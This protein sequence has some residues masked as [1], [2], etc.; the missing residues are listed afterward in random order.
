MT[1]QPDL[2]AGFDDRGM[3]AFSFFFPTP[4]AQTPAAPPAA[5]ATIRRAAGCCLCGGPDATPV[6]CDGPGPGPADRH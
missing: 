3:F 2:G 6:A 4:P 1:P 5:T